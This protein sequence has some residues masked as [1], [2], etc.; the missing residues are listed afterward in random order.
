M[1]VAL[2]E[3][4]RP[5]RAVPQSPPAPTPAPTVVHDHLPSF[6]VEDSAQAGERV[7][8]AADT[9]FRATTAQMKQTF[10]EAFRCCPPLD[11]CHL[12]KSRAPGAVSILGASNTASD[13]PPDLH[14]ADMAV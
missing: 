1:T 11:S 7:H 8:R 13:G 6:E 12:T 9:S 14:T 4:Q 3:V 10:L 5:R 2:A